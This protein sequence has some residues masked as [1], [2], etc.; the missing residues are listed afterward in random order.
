MAARTIL[1][2]LVLLGLLGWE[3]D[4]LWGQSG[5]VKRNVNLRTGPAT[6]FTAIRLMEPGDE[7]TLLEPSPT[8]G[9]HHVVTAALESGWVWRNNVRIIGDTPP[10][11]PPAGPAEVFRGCPLEGNAQTEARRRLNRQKNR[12][13]VPAPAEIDSAGTLAAML[14]PGDDRTRWRSDRAASVVGFVFDVKPGSNET[15]N[16]GA[17]GV[18]NTDVH[19]ELTLDA[20]STGKRQRVVVEVT[21]RWREFVATQGRDWSTAALRTQ[22]EGRCARFVGWLFFDE[23]HDDEAENTTPGGDNNWRATA[24]ELHPVTEI[25]IVPCPT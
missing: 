4:G 13:T 24:W 22:L 23:E 21:P 11:P 9:Y 20:Q 10:P 3:T 17:S 5:V 8:G 18:A 16:C 2:G 14:A 1:A 25:D 6:T 15:V 7:F 19:I 12:V